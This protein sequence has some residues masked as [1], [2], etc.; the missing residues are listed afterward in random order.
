[1]RRPPPPLARPAPPTSVAPGERT[2]VPTPDDMPKMGLQEYFDLG[3]T[4]P[5]R[6]FVYDM[7][8]YRYFVRDEWT[9]LLAPDAD[10]RVTAGS[11]AAL[12]EAQVAGREIKVGIR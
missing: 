12:E 6:N 5:S 2:V 10:G 4:G 11:F 8:V 7:E 1:R 9:E 3:T